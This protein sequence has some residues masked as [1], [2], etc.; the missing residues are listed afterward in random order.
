MHESVTTELLIERLRRGDQ[1]A[2]GTLVETYR[3]RVRGFVRTR[4]GARVHAELD[5]EDI[6]QETFLRALEG[7]EEFQ[8]QGEPLFFR[9]LCGIAKNVILHTA[10]RRKRREALGDKVRERSSTSP[11]RAMRRD[12]RFDRLEDA[13]SQLPAEQRDVLRLARLEGLTFPE[14]ARRLDRR[15]DAVRQIA[16]R[17]L[18]RL[19]DFFGDTESL[20]LP[21]RVFRM[22]EP[23][24]EG[25][26]HV[27]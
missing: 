17:A 23:D 12:E 26:T 10:T 15:P 5:A 27:E 25:E 2:F 11:S 21:D 13:F 16:V 20:G 6:V 7:L 14:I 1:A 8:W 19:R 4:M 3:E 22:E 24:D 18:R 9:W